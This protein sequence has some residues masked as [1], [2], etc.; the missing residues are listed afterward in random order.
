LC[1]LRRSAQV[2][3]KS[4]ARFKRGDVNVKDQDRSSGSSVIDDDEIKN[5]FSLIYLAIYRFSVLAV[6]NMAKVLD[7]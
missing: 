7:E 4:F 3:Y 2:L 5:V 6:Y 1:C